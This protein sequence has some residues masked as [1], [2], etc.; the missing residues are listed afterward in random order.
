MFVVSFIFPCSPINNKK[1][2]YDQFADNDAKHCS[3]AAHKVS[4]EVKRLEL[5]YTVCI[6]LTAGHI[7]LSGASM[8]F[9]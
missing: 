2:G 6:S 5:Q 3:L 8:F 9:L 4:Y 1:H 7:S